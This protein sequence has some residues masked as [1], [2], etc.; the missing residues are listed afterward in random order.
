[1][2][3]LRSLKEQT[4]ASCHWV[5]FKE[6]DSHKPSQH[7]FVIK[8]RI[9]EVITPKDLNRMLELEFSERPGDNEYSHFHEDNIILKKTQMECT[10]MDGHY[11]LPLLLWN[12]NVW[13]PNNP[14]QALHR[15]NWLK[16]K[17]SKNENDYHY[18]TFREE[19]LSKGYA[20]RV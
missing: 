7:H 1:M 5:I 12:E 18:V 20:R 16:R 4:K 9:K 10:L 3:P 2:G 8:N 14:D 15:M 6:V 19:I 17:F 13:M 11:Q